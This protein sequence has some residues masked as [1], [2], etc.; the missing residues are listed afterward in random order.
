VTH[1]WDIGTIIDDIA[2]VGASLA[3]ASGPSAT[4]TRQSAPLL[5]P[6]LPPA[7][8]R[9]GHHPGHSVDGEHL[10]HAQ[11]GLADAVSRLG[12]TDAA[13]RGARRDRIAGTVII[14]LFTITPSVGSRL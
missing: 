6:A 5:S 3:A 11:H 10:H 8:D 12:S 14:G 7:R 2:M 9:H 4:L 13:A 1:T